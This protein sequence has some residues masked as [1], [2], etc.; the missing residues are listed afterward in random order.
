MDIQSLF[1]PLGKEYCV[2]FYWLSVIGFVFFCGLIVSAVVA[3]V[4][5][6]MPASYY[7]HIATAC[8]SNAILYF[9]SR[10]LYSMCAN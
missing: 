10:L 1:S 5:N 6:K 8:V 9:Q 3:A 7:I 4:S 2:Y